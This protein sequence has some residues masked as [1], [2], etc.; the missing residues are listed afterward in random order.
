[1]DKTEKKLA[2][3]GVKLHDSCKRCKRKLTNIE[4]KLAGCGKVCLGKILKGVQKTLFEMKA[5]K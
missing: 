3:S 5:V 2:D 1:M 4:S